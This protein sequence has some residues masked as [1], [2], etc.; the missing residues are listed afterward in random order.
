M[1]ERL[2]GAVAALGK[3]AEEISRFYTGLAPAGALLLSC[4][5]GIAGGFL[6]MAL[7]SV[8]DGYDVRRTRN[9]TPLSFGLT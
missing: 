5:V 6:R 7:Y 4:C 9:A 2:L 3:V 8:C 1:P